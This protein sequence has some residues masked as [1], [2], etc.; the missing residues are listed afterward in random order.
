MTVIQSTVR[1][2]LV[3]STQA[4][5]APPF[6]CPCLDLAPQITFGVLQIWLA[7]LMP[8]V[9]FVPLTALMASAA[10]VNACKFCGIMNSSLGQ[11]LWRGWQDFLGLLGIAMLPQVQPWFRVYY[12]HA[13]F[14][15]CCPSGKGECVQQCQHC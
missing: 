13:A 7:G 2:D 8:S 15:F 5:S 3:A 11:N 6:A 4:Q 14:F 12:L 9:A 10:V 1:S